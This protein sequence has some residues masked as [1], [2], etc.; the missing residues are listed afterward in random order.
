MTKWLN[1]GNNVAYSHIK[2]KQGF[3][4][5]DY[6]GGVLASAVNLDP[7][8][9]LTMTDLNPSIEPYALHLTSIVMDANGYPYAISPYVGQEMTNPAAYIKT[10]NGNFSWSDNIVGNMY[11][12]VQ[13]VRGLQFRSS[14]GTKLAFW[15][16]DSFTPIYFLSNTN[17]NL[18]Q[19]SF[20][21]DFNR[22]FTWTFT[23]TVSY[24]R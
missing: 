13:P 2:N 5:N 15:G 9:P 18:T 10:Q 17:S 16:G 3:S 8:T 12:E 24:T 23:N 1:F 7:V 11:L 21:R 19:N 20:N 6:F 4:A 22:T 14:I